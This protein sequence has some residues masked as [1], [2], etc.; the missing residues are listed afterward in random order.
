V[1]ES[2]KVRLIQRPTLALKIYAR[3]VQAGDEGVIT[4]DLVD[5]FKGAHSHEAVS[6]RF[7]EMLECG[8]VE[9]RGKR[10]TRKGNA[11]D[12]YVA[13]KGKDFSQFRPRKRSAARKLVS[14]EDGEILTAAKEFVSRRR[15]AKNKEDI[16]ASTVLLVQELTRLA[17]EGM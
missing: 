1:V 10:L 7:K 3:V 2:R 13:V 15:N 12:V 5:F 11:S 17:L 14:Q 9:K 8:L 16:R 4:Q 6:P